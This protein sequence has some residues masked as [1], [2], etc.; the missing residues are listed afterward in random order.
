VQDFSQAEEAG[1]VK[2]L[3]ILCGSKHA[4]YIKDMQCI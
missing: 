2:I 3:D 1:L 4:V